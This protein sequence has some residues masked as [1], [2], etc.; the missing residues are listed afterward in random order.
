MKKKLAYSAAV[1][2]LTA[3]LSIPLMGFSAEA[4]G[5]S[6]IQPNQITLVSGGTSVPYFVDPTIH[7]QPLDGIISAAAGCQP[8]VHEFDK[9]AIANGPNGAEPAHIV[10]T[11]GISEFGT[12]R[13]K[14]VAFGENGASIDV[15]ITSNGQKV[16]EQ[17]LSLHSGVDPNTNKPFWVTAVWL[18]GDKSAHLPDGD[19][20]YQ[21]KAKDGKGHVLAVWA[22]KNHKFTITESSVNN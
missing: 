20:N 13:D 18:G 19:Y 6:K 4:Q 16:L 8:D 21:F 7:Y 3:V 10:F 15:E 9:N 2:G 12:D 17:A 14:A 11:A 22:P 5:Q 1:L